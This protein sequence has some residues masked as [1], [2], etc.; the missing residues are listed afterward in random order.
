MTEVLSPSDPQEFKKWADQLEQKWLAGLI[1]DPQAVAIIVANHRGEVLLQLRDDNPHI[2]FPNCWSLPGGVVESNELPDQA[3]Q[4]ELLE[5][6]GLVLV[7]SHWKVYKWK[8][9]QRQ[10]TIDQHIYTGT[11]D[12]ECGEMTL[13]E[14]QALRFFKRDE[15]D[16]LPIANDFGKLLYEYF[17]QQK[18]L[19]S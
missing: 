9:Q 6:T 7:L 15:I 13:G 10:L 19:G 16:S 11:T 12:K 3:A 4:R 2:S 18:G 8:P 1:P 17:D 5:E 14:G